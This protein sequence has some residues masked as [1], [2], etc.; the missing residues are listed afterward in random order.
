M[1]FRAS[2]LHFTAWYADPKVR[3]Q[4]LGPI[5]S[6]GVVDLAVMLICTSGK[7]PLQLEHVARVGGNPVRNTRMIQRSRSRG[8]GGKG[9]FQ[10]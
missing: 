2:S 3:S 10:V 8:R 4:D 5:L 6:S 7:S 9:D 1:E